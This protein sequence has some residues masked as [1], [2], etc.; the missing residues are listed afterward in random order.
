MPPGVVL[1]NE[2]HVKKHV[3]CEGF[4]KLGKVLEY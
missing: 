4:E 3:L 1:T 2:D